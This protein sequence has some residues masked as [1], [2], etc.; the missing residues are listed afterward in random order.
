MKT[1]KQHLRILIIEDSPDRQKILQQLFKD[2]AWILVHTAERAVRLLSVYDFDLIALDFDLATEKTGEDVAQ[3]I[4]QSRNKNAKVIIHS[5][6]HPGAVKIT[7]ILPDA[8][9]VPISKITRDNATF[10]RLRE[11]LTKGVDINWKTVFGGGH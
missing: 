9:I 4:A 11:E 10:K 7:E 6:N 3:F 8:D 2:H 1:L 5:M